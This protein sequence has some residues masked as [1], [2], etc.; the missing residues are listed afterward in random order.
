MRKL[1]LATLFTLAI[2][3]PAFANW[4]I[5][6]GN[7]A[8]IETDGSSSI[9]LVCD[10]NANTNNKPSWQVR[11]DAL[12]VRTMGPRTQV[13][14]RFAGYRP[15]TI[16][17]D[18]RL[19]HVALDGMNMATQGDMNTLVSR[20]KAA[21]RVTVT[22]VDDANGNAMEPLAFNLRGSNRTISQ[23]QQSCK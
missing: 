19:G 5:I 21:T 13:V 10:N 20:L 12:N 2:S 7:T 9:S 1:V 18:N 17:A 14:F 15:L 6:N 3:A 23:I 16:M 11:I 8:I 22:L 4:K